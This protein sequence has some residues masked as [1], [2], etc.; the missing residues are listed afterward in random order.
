MSIPEKFLQVA[1]LRSHR[2]NRGIGHDLYFVNYQN[3]R[4]V[5]RIENE[6]I[7]S[8]LK[9][10]R[11]RF[12][13]QS[14]DAGYT[15]KLIQSGTLNGRNYFVSSYIPGKEVSRINT[16]LLRKIAF[17]LHKVHAIKGKGAGHVY[18]G[19]LEGSHGNWIF[20]LESSLVKLNNAGLSKELVEI[21]KSFK[22]LKSDLQNREVRSLVHGDLNKENIIIRNKR[23]Y[24]LDWENAFVGDPLAD[25]AILDNFFTQD[26][27]DLQHWTIQ[28]RSFILFYKKFFLAKEIAYKKKFGMPIREDLKKLHRIMQ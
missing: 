18:P 25:Y 8:R 28:D 16:A 2:K 20:F 9:L 17:V 14:L 13:L 24:L 4:Y 12:L 15:P 21:K 5:F 27:L 6:E 7:N 10:D 22:D 26:I 23:I 19:R 11:Y 3:K 1:V